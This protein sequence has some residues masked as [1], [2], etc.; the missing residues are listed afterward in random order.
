MV[1]PCQGH[2]GAKQSQRVE[3]AAT[4]GPVRPGSAGLQGARP[5]PR[6]EPVVR[7]LGPR[8]AVRPRDG[9]RRRC[10][11]PAAGGWSRARSSRRWR[12]AIATQ[13]RFVANASHEL[14]TPMT[15]I[16]VARRGRAE[17]PAPTVEE[18][19]GGPAR[20]DRATEETDRLMSVAAD[21]AAARDGAREDEPVELQRRRARR[22]AP[23]ARAS[24]RAGADDRARRRRL[25][26]RAAANLVDNA[27]RHGRP[28]ASSRCASATAS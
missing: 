12:G 9:R 13:R 4:D 20:D 21:L 18:P 16:R 15:A 11:P 22:A 17:D 26:A 2:N 1:A 28:G 8:V 14:R 3:Q 19:A 23:R 5:G 6:L 25:L 10:S 27:L 7:E 24:T